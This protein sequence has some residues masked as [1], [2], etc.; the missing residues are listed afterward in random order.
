M[1]YNVTASVTSTPSDIALQLNEHNINFTRNTTAG[2]WT[3]KA[4]ISL[5]NP[6]EVNFRAV[7]INGAPWSLM[8][9][10]APV[11]TT[12]NVTTYHHTDSI[13]LDML[14]ILIDKFQIK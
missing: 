3:A 9:N 6:V 12:S 14:S 11:N 4:N 1:N 2:D 8:I 13:P 7:G 10:V 5:S